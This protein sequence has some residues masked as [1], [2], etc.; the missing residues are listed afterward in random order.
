[1]S[2]PQL[3]FPNPQTGRHSG[4]V[5][6]GIEAAGS[7]LQK[8]AQKLI[9]RERSALRRLDGAVSFG[10]SVAAFLPGL[11]LEILGTLAD[12]FRRVL[13]MGPMNSVRDALGPTHAKGADISGYMPIIG[14]NDTEFLA[15]AN[16]VMEDFKIGYDRHISVLSED[17]SARELRDVQDLQI[18][19]GLTPLP[20]AFLRGGHGRIS[21]V[22]YHDRDGRLLASATMVDLTEVGSDF[23]DTAILVGVS[24][25]PDG[26]GKGLGKAITAAGLIEARNSLGARR[27]I[28]VVSPTN[29]IA[30]KTNAKF[31]MLPL[32]GQTAVYVEMGGQG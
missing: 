32:A 20:G 2:L 18:A 17:A 9:H 22:V 12:R 11:K 10:R 29:A 15:A 27:V 24:V 31:G 6:L 8:L 4:G 23:M 1:M 26:Q 21:T 28:A 14:A 19:V 13:V 7:P 25:R 5:P 30:L 16:S 3:N